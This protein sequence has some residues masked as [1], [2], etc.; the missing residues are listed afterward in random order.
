[1]TDPAVTETVMEQGKA[2]VHAIEAMGTV[3]PDNWF[4]RV[5]ARRGR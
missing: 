2:L 1:M 3:E 4:E 5:L